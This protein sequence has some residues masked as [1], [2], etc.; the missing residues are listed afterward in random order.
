[1]EDGFGLSS[2]SRLLAVIPPLS[3]SSKAIL[4]FL[5]LCNLMQGMLLAFLILAVGLL[6]LRNVHLPNNM[7]S[8]D[9]TGEGEQKKDTELQIKIKAQSYPKNLKQH[10]I[11]QQI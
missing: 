3:L 6:C 1:V 2:I 5:V 8:L 4:T 7:I 11:V 10:I 9:L